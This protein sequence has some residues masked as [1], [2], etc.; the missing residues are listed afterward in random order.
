M[1]HTYPQNRL[2]GFS[3]VELL[4]VLAIIAILAMVTVS[5]IGSKQKAAVRELTQ[6]M[7]SSL[8]DAQQLARTSGRPVTLHVR[9][10]TANTLTID[11]EYVADPTTPL[12][13]T[14]GGGFIAAAQQGGT[15]YAAIG[16]GQAQLTATGVAL[17]SLTAL[18]LMSDWSTF[19]V[20][21]NSIFQ[22]AESQALTFSSDGQINQDCYLTVSGPNPGASSPLGVV[23]ATRRNGI[24]AY[25]FSGE[26]GAV[27]R[28][29]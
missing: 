5:G 27:W 17:A 23:I 25:F 19:F 11:F 21:A 2:R 16:I 13:I 9:G 7:N 22:G 28:S 15:A 6:Q 12:V 29:L 3:V 18:P 24:H 20:D 8:A 10:T 1:R 14:R 26:P 4:V